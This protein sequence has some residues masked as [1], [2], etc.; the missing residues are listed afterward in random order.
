MESLQK[1]VKWHYRPYNILTPFTIAPGGSRTVCDLKQKGY[2]IFA[3]VTASSPAILCRVELETSGETFIEEFT[4]LQLL[5]A[6]LTQSMTSGWWVSANFPLV[7]S[8]TVTFTPSPWWP[9]DQRI[10]VILVNNTAAPI[11]ATSSVLCII[12]ENKE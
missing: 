1:D 5:A 7:P 3:S 12:L 9:V 11:V 10:K 6:G 8:Y 4:C 2:A